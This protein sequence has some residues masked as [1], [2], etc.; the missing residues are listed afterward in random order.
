MYLVKWSGREIE[1]NTAEHA[2]QVCEGKAR[3]LG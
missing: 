2:D 3:S 1:S